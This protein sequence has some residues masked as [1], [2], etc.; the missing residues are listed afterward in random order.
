MR[1]ILF[2]TDFSS[3][4]E[5]AFE[6]AS[7]YLLDEDC[8]IHFCHIF[9]MPSANVSGTF[10]LIEEIKNQAQ[11]DL[12]EFDYQIAKKHPEWTGKTKRHL[13]Q[14]D[15]QEQCNSLAKQVGANL[16]IMGT[17]GA[18]GIQEKLIGSN[19]SSLIKGLK[20]PLLVIPNEAKEALDKIVF[21]YDGLGIKEETK[22]SLLDFYHWKKFP[23]EAIHI[24]INQA[25]ECDWKPF[26]EIFPNSKYSTIESEN[27]DSGLN[28]VNSKTSNLLCLVRHHQSFWERLFGRSDSQKLIM[29]AK[30]PVLV[31][32]D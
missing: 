19:T 20:I 21:A 1:K 14:G 16:L 17:K 23:V 30:G 8:E 12:N 24:R 29:H 26:L 27:I 15:F 6:Y 7:S 18:S 31:I 3:S 25:S 5:K 22:D 9:Q 4:A 32:P 10:Y 11:K 13:L 28:A 2:P